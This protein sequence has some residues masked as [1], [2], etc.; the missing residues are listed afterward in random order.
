MTKNNLKVVKSDSKK[1]Q[2]I[3][4][5]AAIASGKS[6][7]DATPAPSFASFLVVIGIVS[8]VGFFFLADDKEPEE[9][10]TPREV[11][12]GTALTTCQTM[13]AS[14]SKYPDKADV[15]FVENQSAK[16]DPQYYFAWG[17]ST[18]HAM[19]MNSLGM[20]VPT[21]AS[22]YVNRQTGNIESLTVNAQTIF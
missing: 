1:E 5:Q 15:P 16:Y 22:C 11:G 4:Y 9:Q 12:I 17:P 19:M 13:I 2:E 14:V 10:Y 21:T 8:A 3:K 7:P 18:K 20:L 6:I